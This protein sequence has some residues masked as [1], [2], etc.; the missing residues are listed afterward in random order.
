MPIKNNFFFFTLAQLAA[1]QHEL[2][3]AREA[4]AGRSDQKPKIERPHGGAE[5]LQIAMGL[6]RDLNQYDGF[7]VSFFPSFLL[8]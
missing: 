2:M 6:R 8:L 4:R 7:C 5:N 3:V 1:V